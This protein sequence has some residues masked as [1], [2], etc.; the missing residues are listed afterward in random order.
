MFFQLG[1]TTYGVRFSRNGTTTYAELM[2][3]QEDGTLMNTNV[4]G[5]GTLYYKD[6]FEKSKGRKAALARLLDEMQQFHAEF[7][8]SGN[9]EHLQWNMTHEVRKNIWEEYFKTHRK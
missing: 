4:L 8:I 1:N 2:R 7:S 6:R 3:V 5:I 9:H